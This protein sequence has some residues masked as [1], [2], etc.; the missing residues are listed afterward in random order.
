MN[1]KSCPKGWLFCFGLGLKPRTSAS[2]AHRCQRSSGICHYQP[3]AIA[4]G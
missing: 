3:D 2:S 1:Q 4:S